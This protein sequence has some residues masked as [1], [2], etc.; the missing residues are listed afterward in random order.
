MDGGAIY[1]GVCVV[2][3]AQLFGVTLQPE[4]YVT[5]LFMC[6][7]ASIGGAGIPGGV[8]LFLGMVLTSVGL[9][10]E[11]MLLVASVDR[12][13]DMV[14]TTINVTGDACV[15]VIIDRSENT[16]DTQTYNG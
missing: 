3:F 15:T 12:I 6:T 8:L 7:I 5:L 2:F 9:P 10:I 14:T 13:L 16:L 11:G 4:Q 1:Q